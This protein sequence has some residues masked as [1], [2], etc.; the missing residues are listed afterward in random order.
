MKDIQSQ[1]DHRDVYL[2]QVGI[3]DYKFPL[4]IER[5][6]GTYLG[7]AANLK[8][9]VDLPKE[10]KGTHMSRFVQLMQ[11]NRKY[12]FS[13]TKSLLKQMKE[14]L[15][16]EKAFIQLC[17]TY[18]VEKHAPVTGIASYLD[19]EVKMQARL[20]EEMEFI[21]TVAVPVTTLCPCS[22]E[23]SDYGAHNQR[24]IVKVSL[25]TKKL[26]W[27]EDVVELVDSCASCPIYSLLKRPD[28]KF[29]TEMAYNRPRFV[30][31]VTREVKLKL[32]QLEDLV[33]YKV[34]VDSI[35]SI[36]NHAAFAVAAHNWI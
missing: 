4:E 5:K 28:E 16:A 24:A 26:V 36:H 22:K 10:Q 21:L 20:E 1:V 17:F 35:E 19:I 9:S 6:D 8:L 2:N 3:R 29:V 34:E 13:N 15:E 27:I 30:E 7:V 25:N 12:S 23:I 32:D 33:A 14:K 18:F 31:D 11:D